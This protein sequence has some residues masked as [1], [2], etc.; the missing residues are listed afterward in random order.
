MDETCNVC[1]LSD[2]LCICEEVSKES[3]RLKVIIEKRKWG[4]EY[5]VIK[6]LD[7]KEFSLKD[8]AT[9]LKSRLACGGSAKN[10]V[11]ELQGNHRY[12]ILELL[13]K[14]GFDTTDVDI[15]SK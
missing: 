12:K 11:V 6:G 9:Q 5:T 8:L 1:G 14:M 7:P 4:K 10:G 3:T 15:V 2:D 13:E